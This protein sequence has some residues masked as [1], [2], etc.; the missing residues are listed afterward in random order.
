MDGIN[1]F[2]PLPPLTDE[3]AA[4]GLPIALVCNFAHI[5]GMENRE[6]LEIYIFRS[7]QA[8]KGKMP[9]DDYHRLCRRRLETFK[10]KAQ[11]IRDLI[12]TNPIFHWDGDVP[13]P[14]SP[15]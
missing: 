4:R 2:E 3:E 15:K 11:A 14:N 7:E 9:P 12:G 6:Q 8:A 1:F 5:L 13:R 10:R